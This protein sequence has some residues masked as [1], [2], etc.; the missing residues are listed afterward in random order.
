[1]LTDCTPAQPN[2][3]TSFLFT[4]VSTTFSYLDGSHNLWT[5]LTRWVFQIPNIHSICMFPGLPPVVTSLV[6]QP[7]QLRAPYPIYSHLPHTSEGIFWVLQPPYQPQLVSVPEPQCV[8]PTVPGTAGLKQLF[9]QHT[10]IDQSHINTLVNNHWI[11]I[12]LILPLIMNISVW[13]ADLPTT[14]WPTNSSHLFWNQPSLN[15]SKNRN[16]ILLNRDRLQYQTQWKKS[17]CLDHITNTQAS[18]KA[19]IIPPPQNPQ[20]LWKCFTIR[21]T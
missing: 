17:T 1:M 4:L 13:R 5:N 6:H 11:R 3:C 18:W 7:R 16:K 19:K 14:Y 15:N 2:E 21:F 10:D 12:T 20:I 9:H 8:I